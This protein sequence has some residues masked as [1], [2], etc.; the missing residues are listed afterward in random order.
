MNAFDHYAKSKAESR[1]VVLFEVIHAR[2]TGDA[3]TGLLLSQ[4]V[5]WHGVSITGK[6]RRKVLR[7]GR[8]WVAKA[9]RE[10]K[11]ETW[12]SESQAKRAVAKLRGLGLVDVKTWKFAGRPVTHLS[13]NEEAFMAALETARQEAQSS[14]ELDAGVQSTSQ[15]RLVD[16]ASTPT[17]YTETTTENTTENTTKTTTSC[18]NAVVDSDLIQ[19]NIE[20]LSELGI[21][22]PN[23]SK[24]ARLDHVSPEYLDGWADYAEAR[25]LG[26]GFLVRQIESAADPPAG[27]GHGGGKTLTEDE[28]HER[29]GRY[30]GAAAAIPEGPDYLRQEIEPMLAGSYNLE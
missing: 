5:Y 6:R 7:D 19:T 27:N 25:G 10:W 22:E 12:L 24:L 23:R 8:W 21:T 3:V 26:P 20:R 29:Y 11:A 2:M 28:R 17:P 15:V 14:N 18:A 13:I 16:Q 30:A 4:L 9:H 1:D